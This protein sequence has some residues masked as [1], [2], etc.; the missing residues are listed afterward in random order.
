[1]RSSSRASAG[2]DG[3]EAA[4]PNRPSP[5]VQLLNRKFNELVSSADTFFASEGLRR[6]RGTTSP[7]TQA[8][9]N[10]FATGHHTLE[11]LG[12]LTPPADQSEPSAATRDSKASF[13][14]GRP[15][16]FSSA[17]IVEERRRRVDSPDSQ[18]PSQVAVNAEFLRRVQRGDTVDSVDHP[19]S[20]NVASPGPAPPHPPRNATTATKADPPLPPHKHHG[21]ES[22]VEADV[23]ARRW[24]PDAYAQQQTDAQLKQYRAVMN[25]IQLC[26][27]NS[28]HKAHLLLTDA[29][30][31]HAFTDS[32]PLATTSVRATA[33]AIADLSRNMSDALELSR[34][35]N[36]AVDTCGDAV[37]AGRNEA[38][39]IAIRAAST[40]EAVLAAVL[41][42]HNRALLSSTDA[43]APK[44]PAAVS[45]CPTQAALVSIGDVTRTCD[46]VMR[47]LDNIQRERERALATSRKALAMVRQTTAALRKSTGPPGTP[48][49]TP[50]TSVRTVVLTPRSSQPASPVTAPPPAGSDAPSGVLTALP[51]D[52][53]DS[54]QR[55]ITLLLTDMSAEIEAHAKDAA[56]AE[57]RNLRSYLVHMNAELSGER[58]RIEQLTLLYHH[59]AQRLQQQSTER[60]QRSTSNHG[61]TYRSPSGESNGRGTPLSRDVDFGD[62]DDASQRQG[63]ARGSQE[64]EE[65]ERTVNDT[66]AAEVHRLRRERRPGRAL[67]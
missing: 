27:A 47:R 12:R 59:A 66:L 14:R 43:E 2:S 53:P 3:S 41:A 48:V 51:L 64:A 67:A 11:E 63:P 16:A 18:P 35:V 56:E 60:P 20:T 52:R 42:L 31:D 13:S 49:G 6:Q 15:V 36:P 23:L 1:M 37:A 44:S 10:S 57:V 29:G 7:T 21:Q 61:I 55:D 46:L 54:L 32:A 33:T 4:T 26:L 40:V 28:L 17:A 5:G 45:F 65:I 8:E 62:G 30:D 9:L 34:L 24:E 19:P 50:R 38:D 25:K 58:K 22:A 39:H